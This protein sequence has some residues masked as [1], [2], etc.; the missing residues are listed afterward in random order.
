M[1]QQKLAMES[2]TG[3]CTASSRRAGQGENRSVRQRAAQGALKEY[4]YNESRYR[5]LV[6]SDPEGRRGCSRWRRPT[7]TTGEALPTGGL[8]ARA[9]ERPSRAFASR[10]L[11]TPTTR[12]KRK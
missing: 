4:I 12:R 11:K 6:Q 2:G 1:T 5:Q 10:H 3:R 9:R 8:D 7:S